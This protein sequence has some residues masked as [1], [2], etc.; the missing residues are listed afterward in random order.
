MLISFIDL[1]ITACT[2]LGVIPNAL[3]YAVGVGVTFLRIKSYER[4]TFNIISVT[5]GTHH[6]QCQISRIKALRNT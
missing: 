4:V 1:G 5:T 3:R 6:Y 2:A